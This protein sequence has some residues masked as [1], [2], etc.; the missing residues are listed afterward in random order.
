MTRPAFFVVPHPDDEMSSWSLVQ[1]TSRAVFLLMTQG[2]N[3]VFCEDEGGRG[4]EQCKQRRVSSWLKFLGEAFGKGLLD[5]G[6]E[7]DTPPHRIYDHGD[8][9]LTAEEVL[10]SIRDAVARWGTPELV[11]A[12]GYVGPDY[13]HPD[14]VAVH[15]GVRRSGL[16]AMGAT[17]ADR[18]TVTYQVHDHERYMGIP[19]GIFQRHYRWLRPPWWP[20]DSFAQRQTFWRQDVDMARTTARIAGPTRIET[21]VEVSREA[22]PDGA[23]EVYLARADRFPDAVA[24]T[25][26]TRRGPVLLVDPGEPLHPAVASEI[27]RLRPRRVVA[28]G[29][30]GAVSDEVL[31]QAARA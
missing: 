17:S 1:S 12:A 13:E 14:H 22:F 19:D 28:V 2:E 21:A 26:L 16:P 20:P 5:L 29:G 7:G 9:S 27:R 31:D 6:L 4:S 24:A 11:V 30:P 25:P 3:S 8:G 23:E 10:G 18:G 15:E